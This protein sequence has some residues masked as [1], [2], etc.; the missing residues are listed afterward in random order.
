MKTKKLIEEALSLPIEERAMIADS[1]LRSLN[2]PDAAIDA[3]WAE[4]AKRRRDEL[5]AGKVKGIPGEE[6]FAEVLER[7]NK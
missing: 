6:V 1:L 5:R 7:I 3:R 4:A 2:S